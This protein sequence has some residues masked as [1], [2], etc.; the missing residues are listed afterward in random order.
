MA[1][2]LK[3]DVDDLLTSAVFR[4]NPWYELVLFDRLPP[5]QQAMFADLKTRPDFY[6]VMRPGDSGLSVK[7]VTRETALL[8][9]TLREEGPLPQY[10]RP[11]NEEHRLSIVRLVLDHILQVRHG[12]QFVSGADAFALFYDLSP[13]AQRDTRLQRLSVE[14]LQYGQ[15]LAVDDVVEM[16]ARLYNYHRI[17]TTPRWRERFPTPER[18]KERLGV[19]PNGP[20][21]A[22]LEDAWYSA[23]GDSVDQAT[24]DAA[25]GW[26]AWARRDATPQSHDIYKLYISPL[27]EFVENVFGVTLRTLSSTAV[28]QLK[29]GADLEGLLRPDKMVA[30]F[31]SYD[32][33]RA[34]AD[35]LAKRLDGCPA[36]GVPFTAELSGDGLLSWGCDPPASE[37][38]L[39]WQ[40]Q[41]SWRL[42]VTN[43]LANGLV[44]A[45]VRGGNRSAA[46]EP[47]QYALERLELE[48]IDTVSWTVA[49]RKWR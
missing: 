49:G 14:A 38:L 40:P 6:G 34:A 4:A 23:N 39:G 17:P 32:D 1:R 11:T 26:L 25:A 46:I 41:E 22:F 19:A 15:A 7:S 43:R 10:A 16:S 5:A 47:W 2:V 37:R 13:A 21:A 31:A 30:Y 8:Y 42:W 27:P 35:L 48:G 28:M 33:V 20:F 9:L 36:H 24:H 29:I 18:V 12:E 3:A 44:T 45:R